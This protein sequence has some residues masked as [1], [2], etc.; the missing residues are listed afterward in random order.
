MQSALYFF[1]LIKN[2]QI[3]LRCHVRFPLASG[4]SSA[5]RPASRSSCDFPV[6][7]WGVTGSIVPGRI[8]ERVKD[9]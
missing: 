5:C 6:P 8:I 9:S 2:R 7:G 1:T 3:R 4:G